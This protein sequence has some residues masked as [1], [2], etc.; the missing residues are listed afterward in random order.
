MTAVSACMDFV[1]SMEAF[2]SDRW[3][4]H[5]LDNHALIPSSSLER[6][7]A[8]PQHGKGPLPS[9]SPPHGL[10]GLH[11]S[12]RLD[13]RAISHAAPTSLMDGH[14]SLQAMD[15]IHCGPVSSNG[16][17]LQHAPMLP[18]THMLPDAHGHSHSI[19]YSSTTQFL[20]KGK[21]V[22]G[23]QQLAH[24]VVQPHADG[25]GHTITTSHIIS[26]SSSSHSQNR[27]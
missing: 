13:T 18:S 23:H 15:H 1:M 22:A 19:T 3:G 5:H 10:K 2:H 7:N 17:F 12:D 24:Q 27:H 21:V 9:N 11:Y 4:D 14:H 8:R 6:M 16:G 20:K 26:S 25:K